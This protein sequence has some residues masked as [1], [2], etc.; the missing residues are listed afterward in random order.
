MKRPEQQMHMAVVQH[1]QLRGVP[2]L[3]YFHVPNGV[4]ARGRKAAILGGIGKGMGVRAG[5]SDLI[6]IHNSNVYALELKAGNGA[7]P[8]Q[9]QM[10]FMS[11][12]N[13]AGGHGVICHDLDRAL[14]MLQTWGLLRGTVA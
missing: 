4:R 3:V 14:R 7:R 10:E 5:V 12:F 9:A 11:D 2:G 1:L 13:A 6:L 8:T